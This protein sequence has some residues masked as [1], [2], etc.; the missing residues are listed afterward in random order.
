MGSRVWRG[1][2]ARLR[3]GGSVPRRW[4]RGVKRCGGMVRKWCVSGRRVCLG[5]RVRAGKSGEVVR[6]Y[7]RRRAY[8]PRYEN[9]P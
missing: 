3:R 1:E 8:Q 2:R 7:V 4:Q 6:A 5:V 9:A